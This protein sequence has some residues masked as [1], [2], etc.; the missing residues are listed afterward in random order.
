MKLH[1]AILFLCFQTIL[2]GIE[3]PNDGCYWLSGA[4]GID[5]KC[6]QDH[7]IV[8]ACGAGREPDCPDISWQQILCCSVP[9]F[10]FGGCI[11]HGSYHGQ[12]NTCLEYIGND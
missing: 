6:D 10:Y 12:R 9:I 7:V 11:T 1:T 3:I 5:L 2:A 4:Y 8:G